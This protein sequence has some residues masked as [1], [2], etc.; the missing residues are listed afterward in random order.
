MLF[1]IIFE[2]SK[3]IPNNV[4][5]ILSLISF[6]SL[7]IILGNSENCGLWHHDP[8]TTKETQVNQKIRSLGPQ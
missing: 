1:K 7:L 5:P 8:S 4:V 3:C 2:S 6:C